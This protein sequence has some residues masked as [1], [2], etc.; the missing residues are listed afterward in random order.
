MKR[1]FKQEPDY[2][3]GLIL[4]FLSCLSLVWA[5]WRDAFKPPVFLAGLLVFSLGYAL[6]W[7]YDLKQKMASLAAEVAELRQQIQRPR[8]PV[9]SSECSQELSDPV[10]SADAVP[11]NDAHMAESSV[12]AAITDSI[13]AVTF[14]VTAV[15]APPAENTED[16]R[17]PGEGDAS[18]RTEL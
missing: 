4:L 15:T 1:I 6:L 8:E 17:T 7:R 11:I 14:T 9:I 3:W 2:Y 18:G 16:A 13:D 12:A 5:L 10:G